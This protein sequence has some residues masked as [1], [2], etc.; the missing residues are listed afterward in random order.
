MAV[1]FDFRRVN[2]F[3][4]DASRR[5][6]DNVIPF[7]LVEDL[8]GLPDVVLRLRLRQ[9]LGHHD[10]ELV[11]VDSAVAV[12]VDFVDHVLRKKEE[13]EHEEEEEE[14]KE[15]EKVKIWRMKRVLE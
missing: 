15:E 5:E 4:C 6:E 8:E 10:D 14:E 13:K 3:N 9:L 7:H 1:W 12:D 11:K 2:L